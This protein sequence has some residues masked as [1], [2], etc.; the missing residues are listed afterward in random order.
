MA[1]VAPP[2]YSSAY[3]TVHCC[4]SDTVSDL[5][6]THGSIS[7]IYGPSFLNFSDHI[8]KAL[9]EVQITHSWK[10][11]SLSPTINSAW[12]MTLPFGIFSCYCQLHEM[13]SPTILICI[14]YVPL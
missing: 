4:K 14:F 13:C 3:Y 5:K 7:Y 9:Q 2:T 6:V 8:P 10:M 1:E 12:V 11:R